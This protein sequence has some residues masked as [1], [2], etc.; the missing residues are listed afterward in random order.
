MNALQMQVVG[1]GICLDETIISAAVL[2]A[3]LIKLL[4]TPKILPK[5]AKS[6][7]SLASP[8]AANL[9]VAMAENLMAVIPAKHGGAAT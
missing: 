9:I 2:S 7:Q 8:N 4:T 3:R 6:A 5:M 1:G